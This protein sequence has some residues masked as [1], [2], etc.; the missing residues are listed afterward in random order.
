MKQDVTED[1]DAVDL[2]SGTKVRVSQTDP[3]QVVPLGAE[4]NGMQR[5]VRSHLRKNDCLNIELLTRIQYRSN[6]EVYHRL[7]KRLLVCKATNAGN[8]SLSM[9]TSRA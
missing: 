8:L 5:R 3:R 6:P 2:A 4:G 9:K 7:T 1:V